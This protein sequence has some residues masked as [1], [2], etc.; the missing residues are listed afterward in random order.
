MFGVSMRINFA[1]RA[2]VVVDTNGYERLIN[3]M[4]MH[5]TTSAPEILACGYF[6]SQLF[7]FFAVYA[8]IISSMPV[9]GRSG[10]NQNQRLL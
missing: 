9:Y 5:E 2:V 3:Q 4:H 1:S 10:G 6:F 7:S 8:F